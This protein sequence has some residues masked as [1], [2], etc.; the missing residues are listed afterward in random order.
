MCNPDRNYL[1]AVIGCV[2]FLYVRILCLTLEIEMIFEFEVFVLRFLDRE[3]SFMRWKELYLTDFD[4][5]VLL[6]QSLRAAFTW[7]RSSSFD[8]SSKSW[9]GRP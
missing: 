3:I 2:R 9:M 7:L 6:G 4:H 1:N 5:V 8:A